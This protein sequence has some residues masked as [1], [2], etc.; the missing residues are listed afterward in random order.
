MASNF[1]VEI[2]QKDKVIQTCEDKI[3]NL[4][5]KISEYETQRQQ[6][7]GSICLVSSAEEKNREV[8]EEKINNDDKIAALLE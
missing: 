7:S 1:K 4:Q 3:K 2:E 5:K 8:Q 6:Q